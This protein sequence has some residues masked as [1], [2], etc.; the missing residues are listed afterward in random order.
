M[1]LLPA[2]ALLLAPQ[3]VQAQPAKPPVATFCADKLPEAQ[4]LLD[5]LFDVYEGAKT[6]RGSFD[7]EAFSCEDPKARKTLAF[8]FKLQTLVRYS[9]AGDLS[10]EVSRV[11][12]RSPDA[13]QSQTLRL[14]SDDKS[15][16]IVFEEQRAFQNAVHPSPA[17]MRQIVQPV[18]ETIVNGL[19]QQEDVQLKISRGKDAGVATFVIRAKVDDG[20]VRVVLD[21]QTRALRLLQLESDLNSL[22]IRGTNQVFDAPVTDAEFAWTPAPELR[23]VEPG[24]IPLPQALRAAQTP[25]ADAPAT[26]P[27]N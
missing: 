23:Q 8:S 20:N 25:K 13:A 11:E 10:G 1:K 26:Q 14:V 5:N 17:M 18:L 22:T 15:A 4:E 12:Y 24:T 9:E 6:F 2:V 27:K 21:A 16:H 3:L 7:I 19:R